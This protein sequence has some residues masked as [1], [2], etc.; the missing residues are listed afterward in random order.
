MVESRVADEPPGVGEGDTGRRG[1]VPLVVGDNLDAVVGRP[2]HGH[3]RVGGAEVDAA[4]LREGGAE[5]RGGWME[6][7]E[8]FEFRRGF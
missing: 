8:A 3:A 1:E 6:E 2:P 7:V 5:A 4:H